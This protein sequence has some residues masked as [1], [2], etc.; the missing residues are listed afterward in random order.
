MAEVPVNAPAPRRK[1]RWLKVIIAIVVV[2]VVLVVAVYF[3]ATSSA[4]FKGVI[5]PRASKA[6]NAEITVTDASIS[7]FKE[8][9]L[10][11]L[12][13]RTTGDEPL[14]SAP[15]VRARYRLMDILHGNI[16]VDEVTLVS[17]AIVLVEN[18]DGTS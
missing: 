17:P 14:V 3:T 4:F 1:G 11:N 2:F 10:H 8:V 13:V 6:M 15:E 5:L 16:N 7:P 18:P 12:K 9:V